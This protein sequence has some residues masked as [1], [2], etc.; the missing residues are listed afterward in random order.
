MASRQ[1]AHKLHLVTLKRSGINRPYW[2]KRTLQAL[3][4]TKLH[5]SVV[6][7]NAPS[8]NGM[9][10]SVKE[11]I[12]VKPLVIRTDVE[13]SPSGGEFVMH[14]GQC[15]LKQTVLEGAGAENGQKDCTH[16]K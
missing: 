8:V 3:G 9:L 16:N 4:L 2:Q 10:A 5:R 12:D 14:N 6:H 13:S 7:K 11:L 1:A 15:F